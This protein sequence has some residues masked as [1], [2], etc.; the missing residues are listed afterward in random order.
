MK[1]PVHF[2][3]HSVVH[4]YSREFFTEGPQTLCGASVT[5]KFSKG[6]WREEDLDLKNTSLHVCSVCM[7]KADYT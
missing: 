1:F 7:A 4:V 2:G 6:R 3:A 5:L